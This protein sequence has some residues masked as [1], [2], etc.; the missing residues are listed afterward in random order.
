[1]MVGVV[2]A[3]VMGL[4]VA[5]CFAAAR[6]EVVL[7]D[8]DTNALSS[9]PSR[10]RAGQRLQALLGDRSS[11]GQRELLTRIHRTGW[12]GELADTEF[13]VECVPERRPV[14]EQVFRDLDQACR[15]A[16]ILASCT[17][18]IPICLLG[19]VTGRPDRVIGTHFMNPAPLKKT[20]EVIRS[21]ATSDDTLS[22]S[23]DLLVTI[24]KKGIVVADAPGFVSNRVL[25]ITVNQ[26][27]AVVHEG[28][29]D[30]ATVDEIFED[31]VGYKMGPLRTADLIG[32]DVVLDS[33][34]VLRNCTGSQL[35]EPCPLLIDL[36]RQ[37][38]LGRKSGRGLYDYDAASKL[39]G[40]L[41]NASLYIEAYS[42]RRY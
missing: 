38:R 11:P 24:G 36:V 13:V 25:M 5:Q 1:M 29:A 30:V 19:A 32:L 41:H 33:L 37:G 8:P 4:G 18:A 21:P 28:T 23:L 39:S 14:K 40:S 35:F 34:L 22:R 12:L 26:A 10:I 9:V 27:I 31:C 20:V 6:H 2:G 16:T 15:P 7:T 42:G 17:S 3:G